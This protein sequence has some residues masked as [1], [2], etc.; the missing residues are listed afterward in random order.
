MNAEST[1]V[2]FDEFVKSVMASDDADKVATIKSKLESG[3]IKL[4]LDAL[5]LNSTVRSSLAQ[6]IVDV[7]SIPGASVEDFK[8]LRGL[9]TKANVDF[10]ALWQSVEAQ[11]AGLAEPMDADELADFKAELEALVLELS[12]NTTV[13]LYNDIKALLGTAPTDQQIAALNILIRSDAD[14]DTA[15]VQ[16][17][18]A[19]IFGLT[20]AAKAAD[21]GTLIE[22]ARV[23]KIVLAVIGGEVDAGFDFNRTD[24]DALAGTDYAGTDYTLDDERLVLVT[25]QKTD[26]TLVKFILNYNIFDVTVKLDGKTYTIGS[27]D[28]VSIRTTGG[29]G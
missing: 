8:T 19:A 10:A 26:G 13:T 28:Y 20:D 24:S 2:S 3:D 5:K 17:R 25:Y 21:L 27:Y 16:S 6:K 12:D 29:E 4:A 9:Y 18:I 7:Y 15:A 14:A 23:N 22:A 11:A 1:L